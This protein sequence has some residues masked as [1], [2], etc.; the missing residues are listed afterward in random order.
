[1]DSFCSHLKLPDLDTWTLSQKL[2]CAGPHQSK[3]GSLPSLSLSCQALPI[4]FPSCH[5]ASIHRSPS[6]PLLPFFPAILP[7]SLLLSP[8]HELSTPP[9]PPHYFA[10]P[11]ARQVEREEEVHGNL[12]KKARNM[13]NWHDSFP[14]P[15]PPTSRQIGRKEEVTQKLH[16]K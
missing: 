6:L 10:L 11:T 3:S 12:E 4:F 9:L 5:S 8:M 14:S 1:M 15:L 7:A 13:L 2:L 16:Q